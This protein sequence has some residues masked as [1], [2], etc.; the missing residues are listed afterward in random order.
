MFE[1]VTALTKWLHENGVDTARWGDAGSKTPTSLWQELQQGDCTLQDDPPM[2]IVRVVQVII[3]QAG[4]VLVEIEQELSDGR[5]R[6]R[7]IFPAEKMKPNETP[8]A[9]A[10]RCLQ[11]ELGDAHVQTISSVEGGERQEEFVSPSYPGL[12]TQY[13]FFEVE[14]HVTGLST[15]DFWTENITPTDNDPVRRHHWAWVSGTRNL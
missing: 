13:H 4:K 11:E 3:R 15:S 10:Q 9:A 14:M 12:Q 6:Q 7:H 2:R 8:K 5:I 1:S